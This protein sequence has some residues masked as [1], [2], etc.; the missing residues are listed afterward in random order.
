MLPLE[1]G[2]GAQETSGNVVGTL[3]QGRRAR[4][5][6]GRFR[7]NVRSVSNLDTAR[8]GS[9]DLMKSAVL[10]RSPRSRLARTQPFSDRS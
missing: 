7:S 2:A 1:F 5:L 4:Y 10:I 8:D 3:D 9:E 6:G